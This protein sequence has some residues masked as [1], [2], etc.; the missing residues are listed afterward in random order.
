[1]QCCETAQCTEEYPS[2]FQDFFGGIA[3]LQHSKITD[4]EGYDFE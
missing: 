2:A 1:V 3:I 4:V